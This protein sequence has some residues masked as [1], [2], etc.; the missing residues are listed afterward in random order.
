MKSY[1]GKTALVTGGTSGI[2]LAAA[3]AMAAEGAYV[4]LTGRSQHGVDD[5]VKAI[6]DS[7]LADRR[8]LRGSGRQTSED[9]VE[10]EVEFLIRTGRDCLGG[11]G[12]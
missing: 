3:R 6:G 8:E 11:A 10:P 9:G 2:G 5:A 12:P 4:F 7:V 1:S